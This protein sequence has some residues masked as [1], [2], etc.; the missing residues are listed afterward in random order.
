MVFTVVNLD[1]HHA[2]TGWV[3][4]PLEELGLDADAAVPGA[5]PAL[6]R[7]L[8]VARC[9]QLSWRSIRSRRPAHIFRLRRRV[10][11][12][13]TSTTSCEFMDVDRA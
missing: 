12:E 6:R 2:Q 3:E 13:R 4:L 8:S 10:R 11:S 1:P 9:A 7:T 5:R